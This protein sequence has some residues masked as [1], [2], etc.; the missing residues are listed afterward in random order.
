MDDVLVCL[1]IFRI[2]LEN[3]YILFC[4]TNIDEAFQNS[5][6]AIVEKYI[7]IIIE[8]SIMIMNLT[9]IFLMYHASVLIYMEIER[10]VLSFCW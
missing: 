8:R 7:L 2:L 4:P 10:I 6:I 1:C 3:K 9:I 5:F